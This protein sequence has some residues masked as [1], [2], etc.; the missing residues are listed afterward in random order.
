MHIFSVFLVL[1]FPL[2]SSLA[3]E[4]VRGF[5]VDSLSEGSSP[6]PEVLKLIAL[7]IKVHESSVVENLIGGGSGSNSSNNNSP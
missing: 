2:L 1:F 3:D 5:S 7:S 4:V 6:R